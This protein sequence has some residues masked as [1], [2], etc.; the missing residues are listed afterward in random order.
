M[1]YCFGP[2]INES[3]QLFHGLGVSVGIEESLGYL[4]FQSLLNIQA[5]VGTSLEFQI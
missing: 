3:P 5:C 2:N 4:P 1:C